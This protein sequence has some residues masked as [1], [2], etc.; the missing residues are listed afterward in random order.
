MVKPLSF[1]EAL[2]E[3]PLSVAIRT[4]AWL[5]PGIEILHIL[6][7]A[8]VL[9][10]AALFDLRL[11]GFARRLSVQSLARFLLP[12]AA[13]AFCVSV[14]TGVLLVLSDPVYL[15]ANRVLQIKLLLIAGAGLN[16]LIF[17]LTTFKT[18]QLWDRNVHPPL[19]AKL[20]G[21]IS[22]ALWVSVVSAGRLIAY[23]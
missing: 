2:A 19:K 8:F 1:A 11:L 10:S 7:L 14:L 5:Y 18:S 16:A 6:A 23:L 17:H 21:M 13:G 22:L 4:H 20:T 3:T 15:M 9:G 12:I